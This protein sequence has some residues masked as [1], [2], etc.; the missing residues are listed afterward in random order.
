MYYDVL[1]RNNN[2]AVCIAE[3]GYQCIVDIIIIIIEKEYSYVLYRVPGQR[4][5]LLLSW[6]L[7]NKKLQKNQSYLCKNYRIIHHIFVKIIEESIIYL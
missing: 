6:H 1:S 5:A 3:K 4:N 7:N 2:N